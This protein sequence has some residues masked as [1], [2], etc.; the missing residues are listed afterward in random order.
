M[1]GH[2]R[3]RSYMRCSEPWACADE[4]GARWVRG[5]LTRISRLPRTR[6]DLSSCKSI[7]HARCTMLC[8]VHAAGSRPSLP[9]QSAPSTKRA[10]MLLLLL[11]CCTPQAGASRLLLQ[12]CMPQAGASR[13]LRQ[14]CMPQAGARGLAARFSAALL[15]ARAAA[16][17]AQSK[18]AK[19]AEPWACACEG[20]R[21]AGERT[22]ESD[23]RFLRMAG[24]GSAE[25]PAARART[26]QLCS[27][28]LHS[29]LFADWLIAAAE[30]S[31]GIPS[32]PSSPLFVSLISLRG[33]P[34]LT[35]CPP[36]PSSTPVSAT[37]HQASARLW[38][39]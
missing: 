19:P 7:G 23:A 4:A 6:D 5:H 18:R 22:P 26:F 32:L 36:S 34:S 15:P 27:L 38:A 37:R 1:A 31:Y 8:A 2:T 33:Y 30:S 12:C 11:Q 20:H 16:P 17:H 10:L 28:F 9:Q 24:D 14:C 13:L 29:M 3:G 39:C 25:R 35:A 21:A